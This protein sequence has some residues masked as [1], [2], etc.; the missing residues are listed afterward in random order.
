MKR[1]FIIAFLSLC[2]TTPAN[3]GLLGPD[4]Y[5]DCI[6]ENM[7]GVTND[8]VAQSVIAA[9]RT[10]FPE[11]PEEYEIIREV[12]TAKNAVSIPNKEV[13]EID[14]IVES[15]RFRPAGTRG[16]PPGFEISIR[17]YNGSSNWVL[18]SIT[19][20]I[21]GPDEK[22]KFTREYEILVEG[23]RPNKILGWISW[24]KEYYC[25]QRCIIG[26]KDHKGLPLN[27]Y[28]KQRLEWSKTHTK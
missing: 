11:K 10:K 21:R 4:T 27:Q 25:K 17:I 7:K 18:T 8:I 16:N 26:V 9:C 12:F 15:W 23:I 5:E 19:V 24:L 14:F 6:L 3:A 13:K 22:P 28:E 1:F 20:T 2:I